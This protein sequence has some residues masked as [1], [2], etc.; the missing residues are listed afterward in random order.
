MRVT[1]DRLTEVLVRQE[2]GRH[3]AETN[4]VAEMLVESTAATYPLH[5]ERIRHAGRFFCELLCPGDGGA[6]TLTLPVVSHTFVRE[7]H[8]TEAQMRAHLA[9]ITHRD[10][11]LGLAAHAVLRPSRPGRGRD[12]LG[13]DPGEC[14]AVLRTVYLLVRMHEIQEET[15]ALER[16]LNV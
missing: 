2:P 3:L 4:P 13:R 6:A 15:D 1:E 11:L 12:R 5:A 14:E 8:T 16:A 9:R 10:L 7:E